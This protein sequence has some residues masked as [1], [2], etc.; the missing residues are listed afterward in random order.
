MKARLAAHPTGTI[1]P[2]VKGPGRMIFFVLTCI[3]SAL[4]FCWIFMSALMGPS[5][6]RAE[7]P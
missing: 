2:Q 1:C 6:E 4:G 5:G 3:A 7:R